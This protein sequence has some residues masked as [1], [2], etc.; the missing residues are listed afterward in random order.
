MKRL[1]LF[2]SIGATISGKP[3]QKTTDAGYQVDIDRKVNAM[4]SL[5][6]Q[7]IPFFKKTSI[8]ASCQAFIN[9]PSWRVG[10]IGIF[11]FNSDGVCYVFGQDDSV[12]WKEFYD[13]KT[14]QDNDFIPDMLQ[15]GKEGGIVNYHWNNSNMQSYVRTVQKD[16]KTYIIG[17]GFYPASADF[18]TEQLV[19]SAVRFGETHTP[20]ELFEQINN[21]RGKFV[22]GD[23]YLYVYDFEGNVLAHGESIEL[24]GQNVIDEKTSEG[25]FRAREMIAI[26]MSPQGEGWYTY[27]S[28]QGNLEKRVFIKRFVDK[29]TKKSY[30]IAGGYYPGITEATVLDLVKRAISYLREEGAEKAFPEFSKRLGKFATGSVGLFAYDLKGTV[31]ADIANP[32]F[33]G[34]NLIKTRDK[35][36]KYIT[37]LILE[38][39]ERYPHGGW[40]GYTLNNAYAMVYI[41]KVNVP[42]GDF[43]IGATYYPDEKY[44][45]VRFMVDRALLFLKNNP[46]EVAFNMFASRSDDFLRGDTNVFVYNQQGITLV[47]GQDRSKIWQNAPE[48]E[49]GE[50]AVAQKIMAIANSGGGWLELKQNSATR[51]IY[52]NLAQKEPAQGKKEVESE[53]LEAE[54]ANEPETFIIGS[55][56]YL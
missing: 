35:E 4:K 37:R 5:V 46:Q 20:K 45:Q 3:N 41:E 2:L 48:T 29:K 26:A 18:A 11:V 21:P 38:H 39:A 55:G 9:D 40:L 7:A 51:K 53:N 56:Y 1:L 30:M 17:A 8:E 31:V 16:G 6:D 42:D 34:L 43:I 14:A 32:A 10:E 49:E 19:K 24:V 50:G 36:G 22:Q 12:I 13:K 47:N 54:R 52:V 44:I 33:V 23:I 15:V 27:K 25:K 28:M